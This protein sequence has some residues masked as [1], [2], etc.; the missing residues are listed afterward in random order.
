[1]PFKQ[2]NNETTTTVFEEYYNFHL[3]YC[4]RIYEQYIKKQEFFKQD[5]FELIELNQDN[6]EIYISDSLR[7]LENSIL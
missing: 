5:E 4:R 1:M 6:F 2:M 7:I 3:A